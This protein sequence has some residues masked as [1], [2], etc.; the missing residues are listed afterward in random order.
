MFMRMGAVFGV[1]TGLIA[2][3]ITRLPFS[4]T[5]ILSRRRLK[6]SIYYLPLGDHHYLP[7]GDCFFVETLGSLY[8]VAT[9]RD[10]LCRIYQR[11][12]AK[13]YHGFDASP[14]QSTIV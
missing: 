4:Y 9:F 6:Q 1:C 13:Y 7:L 14:R 12:L 2:L 8:S 3:M 11:I 5:D 10:V